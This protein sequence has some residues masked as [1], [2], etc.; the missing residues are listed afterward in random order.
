[1]QTQIL[2]KYSLY[3]LYDVVPVY[4][5]TGSGCLTTTVGAGGVAAGTTVAEDCPVPAPAD[6]CDVRG[7]PVDVTTLAAGTAFVSTING[8]LDKGAPKLTKVERVSVPKA[9]TGT[10]AATLLDG[11]DIMPLGGMGGL[12]EGI[13]PEYKSGAAGTGTILPGTRV[14][15]GTGG[16]TYCWV[17]DD[18]PA[19]K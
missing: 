16:T 15:I 19:G 4:G 8:A 3:S 2:S 14:G 18:K 12:Q 10:D 5:R 17:Y 11:A 9:T 13:T 7:A 6:S 1:L